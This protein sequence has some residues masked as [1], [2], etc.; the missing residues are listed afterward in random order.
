M[1]VLRYMIVM[2][3]EFLG[4]VTRQE[5][6]AALKAGTTLILDREESSLAIRSGPDV[7]GFEVRMLRSEQGSGDV[8]ATMHTAEGALGFAETTGKKG[9]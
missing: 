1:T 9:E 3:G 5:A 8:L 2:D 6:I 4:A 7:D